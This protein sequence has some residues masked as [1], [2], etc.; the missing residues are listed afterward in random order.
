MHLKIEYYWKHMDWRKKPAEKDMNE[1]SGSALCDC[2]I[3]TF[4]LY[5]FIRYPIFVY[6][7]GGA[8][9]NAYG[10]SGAE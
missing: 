3:Q 2:I 6:G 4:K 1:K 10:N 5:D 8:T 9:N 7:L